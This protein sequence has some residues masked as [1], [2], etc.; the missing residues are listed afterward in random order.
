M[1]CEL[2]GGVGVVVVVPTDSPEINDVTYGTVEIGEIPRS[3][4]MENATPKAMIVKPRHKK[5]NRRTG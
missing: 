2:G 3:A 1:I 4:L 5:T